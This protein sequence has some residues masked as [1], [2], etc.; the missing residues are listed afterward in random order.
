MRRLI[1]YF[2]ENHL[3]SNLLFALVVA[4]GIYSWY[5]IRKE[6]YP[7]FTFDVVSVNTAYPGASPQEVEQAI[8]LPL[9]HELSDLAYLKRIESTSRRGSS[10]I[11]IELE[12]GSKNIDLAVTEIQNRV[13]SVNLPA[14]VE[15]PPRVR[16]RQTSQKAVIDVALYYSDRP[17]LELE[18]RRALQRQMRRFE[19]RLLRR[20]EISL[21]D[22][23]AYLTEEIHIRPRLDDLYR[24]RITLRE[25]YDAVIS[26]HTDRPLGILETSEREQVR[27]EGRLEEPGRFLPVPLRSSFVG[28]SIRLRDVADPTY[29]F[30]DTTALVRVNGYEAVVFNVVK[31]SQAGILDSVDAVKE[32]LEKFLSEKSEDSLH[33]V[34]LDDESYGVRNRLSIIS[35]NALIGFALIITVLSLFLNPQ[36][37]LWVSLGIPF[38]FFFTL[39]LANLLDYTVNNMTLAGVIIAMGMLVD[40]AIVVS[41]NISRWRA[42]GHSAVKASLEG[43]REVMAPITA[44]ILTTLAA[45]LPLLAFEGRL[46]L[47]T[48]TIPP[49]VAL[50]LV[51]SLLESVTIL[52]G[53]MSMQLPDLRRLF[54]RRKTDSEQSERVEHGSFSP[55]L[56]KNTPGCLRHC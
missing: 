21:I 12:R 2:I 14:E 11:R 36:A 10:S 6:E 33:A 37:A 49:V 38:S 24:Y 47:L 45:F 46:A 35:G 50:I 7:D 39:I 19:N 34:V 4:A 41:E 55:I 15:N 23:D 52:P 48:I 25:L 13:I 26:H 40:D 29:A 51:G 44:S 16:Y 54:R 5:D 42:Q 30:E 18:D 27:L 22:R 32:E 56:K 1:Q 8:T 28:S 53:H 9:E 20:N 43:T 31:S 3:V 17:L